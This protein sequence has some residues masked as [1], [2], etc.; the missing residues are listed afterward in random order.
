MVKF[1]TSV[2]SFYN[3]QTEVHNGCNPDWL[4]YKG[5]CY[6]FEFSKIAQWQDAENS[7]VKM[8]GHL[9]SILDGDENA[10]VSGWLFQTFYLFYQ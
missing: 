8:G 3:F 6:Y 1:I 10:F 5:N 2:N 7:C 9:A 4:W